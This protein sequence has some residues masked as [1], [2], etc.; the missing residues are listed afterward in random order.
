MCVNFKL[1]EMKLST[2]LNIDVLF[3]GLHAKCNQ[4]YRYQCDQ[5]YRYLSESVV[6]ALVIAAVAHVGAGFGFDVVTDRARRDT[7]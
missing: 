5:R 4:A 2:P 1:D 6:T 3:F 7:E